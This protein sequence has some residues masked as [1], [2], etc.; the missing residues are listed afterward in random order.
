MVL[1]HFLRDISRLEIC[2]KY[3]IAFK[4]ITLFV[5]ITKNPRIQSSGT[6]YI[7]HS[8]KAVI[9]VWQPLSGLTTLSQLCFKI[10][11]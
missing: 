1:Y 5:E 6:F 3:E 11:Y 4:V 10:E 8:V 9:A 2:A 7:Q